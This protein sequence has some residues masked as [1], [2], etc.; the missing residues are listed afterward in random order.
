MHGTVTVARMISGLVV[1]AILSLAGAAV[2]LAAPGVQD[3]QVDAAPFGAYEPNAAYPYGRP[4]PDAPPELAQFDFMIGE[5]DCEEATRNRDGSWREFNAVWN[6]SYFLNGHGIQ[7]R[8]WNPRFSTSNLRIF[9]PKAG[10]WKVT[11]FKMPGYGSGVWMGK[12]ERDKIILRNDPPGEKG[13][14]RISILTF[15][16]IRPDGFNWLGGSYQESDPNTIRGG[17]RSSCKR[18]PHG[19]Q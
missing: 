16:N 14:R 6:A 2:L 18:R 4:H 11:F 15:S 19:P 13:T 9:D 12:K 8:Y 17:W 3:G 7:D 5:F 10:L 1:A